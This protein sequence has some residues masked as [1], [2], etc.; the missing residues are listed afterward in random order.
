VVPKPFIHLGLIAS[1]ELVIKSAYN[2]D[3]IAIREKIITIKTEDLGV[4]DN[5]PTLMIKR[6][7]DY[8][9]SH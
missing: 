9:N 5:F 3:A 1:G 6:V 8:V 7:R 2:Q 4:W